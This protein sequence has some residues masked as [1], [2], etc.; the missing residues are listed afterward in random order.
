L[1]F[2]PLYAVLDADV[3]ARFGW[4][5][6]DLAR[7]CLD[8]G[9]RLLQ[10]RGKSL[11]SSELLQVAS[12]VVELGVPYGATVIV[13]DRADIARLSTAAGVHVG[14]DDLAPADARGIVGADAIVGVSTHTRDQIA[15]AIGS[16]CDYLAVGPVFGTGTK[17]TGY[18]AVGLGLVSS[19]AASGRPVVAIGGIT[20]ERAEAVLAAGATS[21]AVISDLVAHG[22]PHAR[23]RAFVSRLPA[24]GATL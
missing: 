19:A 5:I 22:D 24:R 3:A 15:R 21:V 6:P 18:T 2:P 16:T 4:T 8:G 1:I 7:A 12:T 17:D 23:V 10:V 20:L 13:N 9:A 11:P 14:Q